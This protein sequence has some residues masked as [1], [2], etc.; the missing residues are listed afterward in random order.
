MF[1]INAVGRAWDWGILLRSLLFKPL[2]RIQDGGDGGVTTLTD[3][4]VERIKMSLLRRLLA[5]RSPLDFQKTISAYR[6]STCLISLLWTQQVLCVVELSWPAYWIFV[7]VI[8]QCASCSMVY[9]S[10]L[11]FSLRLGNSA[12]SSL[13][14]IPRRFLQLHCKKLSAVVDLTGET[15]LFYLG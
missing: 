8:E 2:T 11:G 3:Y 13:L 15:L 1:L 4:S 6:G 10:L 14:K 12:S 9:L 7:E 5:L